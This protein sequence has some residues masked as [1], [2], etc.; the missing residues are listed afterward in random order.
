MNR[1]I[2]LTCEEAQAL[3]DEGSEILFALENRVGREPCTE[4]HAFLDRL[5]KRAKEQCCDVQ[6][7]SGGDDKPENP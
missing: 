7:R 5:Q 2:K 6:T 1:E 3:I 4:L